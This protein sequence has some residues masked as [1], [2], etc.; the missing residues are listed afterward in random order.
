MIVRHET[1][2]RRGGSQHVGTIDEKQPSRRYNAM[3]MMIERIKSFSSANQNGKT[4]DGGSLPSRKQKQDSNS[5]LPAGNQQITKNISRPS[6]ICSN[7]IQE[8]YSVPVSNTFD[9]LGN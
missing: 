3:G 2:P 6:V 8:N 5:F 1:H 7:H 9:V 4:Y